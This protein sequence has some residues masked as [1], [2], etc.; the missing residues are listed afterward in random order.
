MEEIMEGDPTASES[1]VALALGALGAAFG[2]TL[3]E[4]DDSEP[5]LVVLQRKAQVEY[6]R[7]RQTPQAEQAARMFVTF[8]QTLRDPGRFEQ[9]D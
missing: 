6:S 3:V 1:Q 2:Q 5:L 7:L 9:I 8:V 4:F